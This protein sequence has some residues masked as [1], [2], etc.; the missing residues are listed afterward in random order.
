M[1][2]LRR[3][4]A[5]VPPYW[6]VISVSVLGVGL[7]TDRR[8]HQWIEHGYQRLLFQLIADRVTTGA[9][10]PQEA[11]VALL[12]YVHTRVYTPP[13]RKPIG[14]VEPL[15]ILGSGRGLC[16]QQANVFIQL[17][18]TIPL[19]GRL[20]FLRTA[21]GVSPHSIAEVYLH[22]AW[23]VADPFFGLV[24]RDREGLLATRQAIAQDPTLLTH[25]PSVQALQTLGSTI[26]F[27][28]IARLYQSPP[29]VFNT[30][31]GKRKVW[32]DRHPALVQA[33]MITV[34]QDLYF[35]LPQARKSWAGRSR[36]L[37]H[38]R[39]CL[40]VGRWKVG[41]RLLQRLAHQEADPRVR[42]DA[43]FFLGRFYQRQERVEEALA[44]FEVVVREDVDGQGW[45][46]AA[47]AA[48]GQ[49]YER[50]DQPRQALQ[51]YQRSHL[52][53]TDVLTAGRVL[54]LMRQR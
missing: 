14:D 34:L 11:V 10:D 1:L 21:E 2:R 33:W 6:W 48:M 52:A 42:E 4:L 22:G 3:R 32:V 54:A 25:H 23:R 13:A 40:L 44:A 18:R 31:R 49:L 37:L 7:A 35:T 45:A 19:D 29:T 15:E 30:W 38:A 16:D 51:A 41:E 5:T 20:V 39:H 36:Q 53:Q 43:W 17:V 8:A 47:L 9:R 24:V 28:A 26:D 12:D 50:L 46:S 27:E